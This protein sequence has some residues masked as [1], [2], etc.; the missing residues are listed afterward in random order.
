MVGQRVI[1]AK[2]MFGKRR[3]RTYAIDRRRYRTFD[4]IDGRRY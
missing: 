4:A 3:Y 2:T 1:G